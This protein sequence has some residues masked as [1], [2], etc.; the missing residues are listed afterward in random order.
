MNRLSQRKNPRL[1]R[2]FRPAVPI[3][4][5]VLVLI[6]LL[7]PGSMFAGDDPGQP[8]GTTDIFLPLVTYQL[9]PTPTPTP[10]PPPVA[11]RVAYG[12][13]TYPITRYPGINDLRAGW[14]VDWAARAQPAAPPGTEYVQMVRVH[15]KLACGDAYNADR[16]NCPYAVP[17]DYRVS[18][19]RSTIV[20]A[21]QANPGSLWL[22]GNEMDRRD[23]CLAW[24][25]FPWTCVP[26]T[27]SIGQDEML[28]EVYAEAYHELYNLI[29]GADPTAQVAIGGVIQPTPLRLQYLDIVW[30]SYQSKY[31]TTMPVDVWN[32]HNFI[33]KEYLNDFGAS[34]PPGLPGNPQ[35]GVTYSTDWTHV[36]MGIFN[37]QIRRFRQWM[38]DKGQQNKPLIVSEYGVLYFHDGIGALSVTKQ[39]MQNTFDY[40]LNTKDCSIGLP[41]DECRLVQRWAWYSLD[42]PASSFGP[43]QNAVIFRPDGTRTELYDVFKSFVDSNF[44][45]L[46]YP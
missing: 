4:A 15:Q 8:T 13:T 16:V 35:V 41:S 9:P 20:A 27:A 23:W 30:N 42:S 6:A 24:Q 2:L 29:K 26:G 46:Q 43:N 36:D 5:F 3:A 44:N 38:K 28:P 12:A 34:I 14:F 1:A 17:Y 39:F 37:E 25:S 21:A 7:L 18:P 32:V 45:A 10:P 31:G 22:I 19:S 40:F 11:D 33:M